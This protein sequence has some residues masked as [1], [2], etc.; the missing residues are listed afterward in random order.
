MKTSESYRNLSPE[1]AAAQ[2]A[3]D[4]GD[5]DARDDAIEA[6]AVSTMADYRRDPMGGNDKVSAWNLFDLAQ[7]EAGHPLD[8]VLSR[9]VTTMATMSIAE[10]A[11][12]RLV[13]QPLADAAELVGEFF[14]QTLKDQSIADTCREGNQ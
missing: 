10:R 1:M 11:Q 6:S 4:Q 14:L 5:M 7:Y 13:S 2:Y 12:L 3:K 9:M 8:K